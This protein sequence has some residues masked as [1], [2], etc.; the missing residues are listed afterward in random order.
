MS[1][2]KVVQS[3]VLVGISNFIRFLA[4]VVVG[5]VVP[6]IMGVE[7]FG[8][9]KTFTLYN[10]YLVLFSLGLIEGI[11]LKYGGQNYEEIDKEKFRYFSRIIIVISI[12]F[13]LSILLFSLS[14]FQGPKMEVFILIG[15]NT[16]A[17]Q[18][19]TYFLTISELSGKFKVISG[20]NLVLSLITI[21]E[22][23]I[24]F[25][26]PQINYFYYLCL[27]VGFN[28][29]ALI[30]YFFFYK[31][32]IFGKSIGRPH[33]IMSL[34]KLGIPLLCANLVTTLLFNLD[35][36]MVLWNY[37]NEEYAIYAF[38][39]SLL[40]MANTLITAISMVIYPALRKAKRETLK[41]NYKLGVSLMIIL[42]SI[43]LF[44]FFP[45]ALFINWYL[46]AYKES[47]RIFKIIIPGLLMSSI[48]SVVIHN[49]FKVLEENRR[50]F[51]YSLVI[52]VLSIVANFVVL[53]VV[54]QPLAFSVASVVIL[55][56]WFLM[57]H[58]FLCQKL[59]IRNVKN[60]V[61]LLMTIVIFYLCTSFTNLYVG[62]LVYL[63]L[64]GMLL[65]LSYFKVFQEI[66]KKGGKIE[67]L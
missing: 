12:V 52:L 27:I 64:V 44:S 26:M 37:S 13:S 63:L 56:I 1:N 51:W 30:Y 60:V 4:S 24:L 32:I 61:I 11:Y 54:N 31:D 59:K 3:I 41:N 38:S 8:Y 15:M 34:M 66:I 67:T 48:I 14:F 49:Y 23:I 50:Y 6:K 9:Y 35:R 10:T 7:D 55:M 29:L 45:L 33:E 22:V 47:L 36:Q 19:M 40:N 42:V 16:L 58:I 39:Y 43:A 21:M 25:F 46:P 20:F 2:K 17:S 62:G 57:G 18:M 28:Y 65:V 53:I 5:L